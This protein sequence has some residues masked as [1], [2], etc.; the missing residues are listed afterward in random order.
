[1]AEDIDLRNEGDAQ[2][3]GNR[4]DPGDFL[5]GHSAVRPAVPRSYLAPE[6]TPGF[7]DRIVH[8]VICGHP[9]KPFHFPGLGL[10]E[11]ADVYPPE[12]QRRTVLYHCLRNYPSFDL[13]GS[14]LRDGNLP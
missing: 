2:V 9:D 14:P 3:V 13:D 7:N 10:V 5:F 11:P 6:G 12:S 1:M 8:L 4:L